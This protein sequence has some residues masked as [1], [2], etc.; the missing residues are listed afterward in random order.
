MFKENMKGVKKMYKYKL[1]NEHASSDKYGNCEICGKYTDSIY[2][3]IEFKRYNH[4]YFINKELFG[5]KD[6]LTK[7]RSEINEKII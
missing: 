1:I 7:E 6:C 4:G 5:H 2:H 3:Q